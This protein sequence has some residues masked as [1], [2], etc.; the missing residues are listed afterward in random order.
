MPASQ[1]VFID[2]PNPASS[3]TKIDIDPIFKNDNS[4]DI[5]LSQLSKWLTK[6][7]VGTCI[8]MKHGSSD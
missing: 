3:P 8:Q 4:V 1:F 7:C 6:S 5:Y 2:E